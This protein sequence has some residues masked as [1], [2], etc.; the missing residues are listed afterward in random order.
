MEITNHGKHLNVPAPHLS[1]SAFRDRAAD[2]AAEVGVKTVE[3]GPPQRLLDRLQGNSEVRKQWLVQVQ[4][5][6]LAGD[7]L[8]RAAA[9]KAAEQI[10]GR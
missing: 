4:A 1:V 9:E 5:K 7:Y 2:S 10:V 3:E 8:S 6:L